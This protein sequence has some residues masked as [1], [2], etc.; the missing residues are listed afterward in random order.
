MRPSSVVF[1][2]SI[3]LTIRLFDVPH[4]VI[5]GTAS[6]TICVCVCLFQ[7]VS[8]LM[9]ER[10]CVSKQTIEIIYPESLQTKPI[11]QPKFSEKR[12]SIQ[13]ATQ[14]QQ[15]SQNDDHITIMK[16]LIFKLEYSQYG[17]A[18]RMAGTLLCEWTTERTSRTSRPIMWVCTMRRMENA[19]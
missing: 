14:Q 16:M 7:C 4:N 8:V 18:D 3:N 12:I 5:F 13:P 17:N 11:V 6:L 1:P 2:I 10:I 9:H 15:H 19:F